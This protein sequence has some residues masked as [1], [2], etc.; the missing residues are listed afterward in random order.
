MLECQWIKQLYRCIQYCY[1]NNKQHTMRRINTINHPLFACMNE[2]IK[3]HLLRT[4][5]NFK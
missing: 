4:V 2:H 3:L 1:A 5:Y